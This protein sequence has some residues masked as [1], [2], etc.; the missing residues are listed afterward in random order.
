[1]IYDFVNTSDVTSVLQI[2]VKP[3]ILLKRLII[4]GVYM[5]HAVKVHHSIILI[6][7]VHNLRAVTRVHNYYCS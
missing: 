1:M 7:Y 4:K 2:T 3:D 5:Q 6:W